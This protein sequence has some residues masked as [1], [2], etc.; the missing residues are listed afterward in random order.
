MVSDTL[1]SLGGILV[2][3][4]EIWDN[5]TT[6]DIL[7]TAPYEPIDPI[8]NYFTEMIF[9]IRVKNFGRQTSTNKIAVLILTPMHECFTSW[10]G[11]LIQSTIKIQYKMF[12]IICLSLA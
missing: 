10:G 3:T 1:T 9:I 12:I 4:T 8:Q 7:I 11:K 5:F 6:S 2:A